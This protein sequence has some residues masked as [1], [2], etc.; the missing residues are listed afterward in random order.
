MAILLPVAAAVI[1]L[2]YYAAYKKNGRREVVPVKD[3]ALNPEQLDHHA[4][5][6]AR[7][8]TVSRKTRSVK[9]LVSRLDDNFRVIMSVYKAINEDA[10]KRQVIS[11]ASEWLLD[12]FYKI[13]EQVK[14][15]KQN[16]TKDK[17]VELYVLNNGILKGYPR[18][19][20]IALELISHTDGRLDQ[21]LLI[22]FVK[23]YQSQAKLS[24]AE[25]WSLSLMVR[26]ALIENIRVICEKIQRT[27]AE[28]KRAQRLMGKKP[29]EL[30]MQLKEDLENMEEVNPSYIEHLLRN[31]RKEGIESAEITEFINEKLA[32][33]DTTLQK[34]IDQEHQEQASRKISI[35]NAIT[36]LNIVSALDWNDIFESLS[37]VDEILREDPAGVYTEMDFES[38]NYYRHQIEKIASKCRTSQINVARKAV[39]CA[40]RAYDRQETC[41]EKFGHVGYYIVGKG[42]KELLGQLGCER[43]RGRFHNHSILV[44][45]API[46]V[47]T[48]LIT[49]AFAVYSYQTAF[50][51][52]LLMGFG[53]AV[54]ALIP[55]SDISVRLVNWIY[56]RILPPAFLPKLEYREGIP[57]DASTLVV[58]PTLLPN[59]GVVGELLA[60]LEVYYLANREENLYFAIAGDFKDAESKE[61]PEDK[62]IIDAAL[63]GIRELNRKYAGDKEIFYFFHRHRQY[64]EKQGKWMGWERKRGALVELNQLLLGSRDTSYSVISGDISHL[65][66]VKYVITLDADTN[67]PLDTAKKL[68]GTISHPLNR[69][70]LDEKKGIVVEGYGIIQPRISVDI[71]SASRSVFTRIF[72]GQGGIDPYT[73]ATS[74]VYQDL[75]GEGIFTGKGIYDLN[76]FNRVL[77]DAIPDNAVLSHD[78]LEGSYI[79]TALATDIE[80]IDSYPARYS[81]YI[82]RQHRWVRGDWQL[83]RWLSSIIRNRKGERVRNPLSALTK[84]KIIDNMR[85]STVPVATLLLILLGLTV[86]PGNALAWIGLAV[87]AA[88]FPVVT[89]VLDS[90]I[91]KYYW[92]VRYKLNGNIIVGVK[93]LFYQVLLLFIFLPHRGYVMADAIIRTLYRVYISR[94][95]LLEWVTAAEAER[96]L[97]NDLNSYIKRMRPATVI[98]VLAI[99]MVVFV[100]PYNFGY[101]LAFG[102]LW[103]L[104]PF[105]AYRVSRDDGESMEVL[106]GEAC[107]EL[108]RLSRKT[109]AFYE[110]F[111]G[112]EN[113]YLVPDNYQ[114]NP[115]NGVAHRT[116]PTNIGFLLLSILSARD[117]GYISTVQ[118]VDRIE[119]TI[120][121]IERLET[122]KGHLYNWYDTR[123]LEVLRPFFVS[124]VDS[125]NLVG[126]LITLKQGLEEY[127]HKP[128]IDTKLV[129][130][131][132]DTLDLVENSDRFDVRPLDRLLQRGT[133]S[134]KEWKELLE[135]LSRFECGKSVWGR[136]FS[137]AV[138]TFRKELDTL[139]PGEDEVDSLHQVFSR[140]LGEL[141][142]VELKEA[143][144]GILGQIQD[145]GLKGRIE[146]VKDSV[147]ML[148]DDINSLIGRIIKLVDATDF[149]SLYD[150][151]RN[152]FSI[153]YNVE[154]GVLMNSYY[155]LLASEARL[156]SYLAIVR[157]EVPKK[158]WFKL[159][160]AL[161]EADGYRGLVS[162]AGTMFEYLMPG[163]VMKGYPNTLLYET[164]ATI[165][166]AQKSYGEKRNV[167]WGTSESGYYAFDML[168]NYQYKAFGIPDFGL[169]RGLIND[170]VVS[171]YST[172]LALPYNPRE[173][174]EN[175][176]RLK[177]EG[178]E[179]EYGFYEA[180]DYTPERLPAGKKKG[181]V[182]S[183]MAHHQGMSFISLNNYFNRNIMQ[184]RFH[185]EP[186]IKVGEILLQEKIPFR[187]IITK[188]YKER[189][190][191]L[192]QVGKEEV[193]VV[194]VLGAPGTGLPH[195]HVLSN[196]RYSVVVTNGG[197]G[198]SKKEDIQVTRWREDAIRDRYGTFIFIRDLC[199]NE[200]WSATYQPVNSPPDGYRAVFCQHKAEF[201]RTDENIETHTEVIVAPEDD[202]EIR[203]VTIS[204][205]GN[206]PV[207]ME[208]TSY[209]ETVLT[210]HSADIAHPAFSNLFVRT[211]ALPHYGSL[212]AYRRPREQGK[213]PVWAVHTIT[214]EGETVGNLQYET[215]RCNFIGRGR[216]ISNPAALTQPLTNTTG[217][218]LDPIMSLRR[219]VRVEPGSS[220]RVAYITGIAGSKDEA[221]ELAKKYSNSSSILR[222]FE[223]ALTRS[224]VETS[225][226][227]LKAEQIKTYQ[228]MI[229]HIIFPSPLKRKYGD[230]IRRNVKGQPGLWAYGISGDVPIVLVVVNSTDHVELVRECLKA[231]EYWRL[232][233][234]KVDLVVL[235]EE[236]GGYMQPVQ[237]LLND[238]VLASHGRHM[239]D[240][241]GGVFIRNAGTMPEEDKI[242]LYTAARIVLKGEEGPIRKQLS[243]DEDR[244]GLPRV[245]IFNRYDIKYISRDCPV[246]LHYFNGYGGF[247]KDGMEYVIKLKE[248]S[249]TPAPWINVV[250]NGNF[251]FHVSESGSGFTWAENSRENKLTPWSN[252]PVSDP[253]GEVLYLRDEENGDTWTVTP[254]PI[255]EK[256]GYIIRHGPG[257][258]VF[259]HD[260]HGIEQELV[261]FVPREEP[262]KINL[263][264]LRN[265]SN[266]K[267][268]LGITYFVKPVMGVSDEVTQQYIYT[269]LDES[270]GILLIRNPYNSDFPGRIAF[271]DTSESTRYYTGDRE[272]FIGPGRDLCCPRALEREH[273]SNRTG[274]GYDPCAA[275]QTVIELNPG[276]EREIAFLLGQGKDREE[277]YKIA[278]LYRDTAACR[279][280]LEE[281]RDYWN[282]VLGTVQV[283]TPDLSMDLM[284]NRWLLYQTIACRLWARSA[285]YQSGGAYGYRDQLQDALNA[286][287]VI[288]EATRGQILLHCAHQFVE[289]DVQHWWH[290]G[291]GNRG[292]RTR[293]SDDLLWLPY[294]TAEY[295]YRTGDYSILEEEVGYLEEEP[296]KEGEDER[297]GVP[298][299]SGEKSSV[300]QHCI[301]AIERSLRFGEHG[302]PLMGSGDW[303]DG[304]NTVGNKGKGES[305]WLGWFL[306]DILRKFAHLCGK[307]GE[308]ERGERYIQVA[309]NI[310]R[311]IEE[312]G[313]DGSWY[314][315]AYF[316]DGTPL[317]S[318]ENTECMIDSIAQSWAIISGAG[319]RQRARQA[320]QA[321]EHYLIR[322]DEGIILLLTPPF[323]KG[324]LNPG[325]IKG[326]VP[327]VREN[328]GQY[329][330]AAC[331]VINA[332][333]M[334]GE[335]NK[336]WELYH[337]INPVNHTRTPIE[338]ATYKVEPYVVAADVY[339]VSPHTGRGGWTWYT[340]AAGWMYSVGIEYILGLRINGQRLTVR[341]CI[342]KDWKEYSITYRYGNT[343]YHIIVKNPEGV[344]TRVKE[345]KIDGSIAKDYIL[346]VDDGKDHQ[347]EVL[348]GK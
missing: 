107:R 92:T 101:A 122:W 335:G 179:G 157:R 41:R 202:A 193:K 242:L 309:E 97:K 230:I 95:N 203:R 55:A 135:Y 168:L 130:G 314:R 290:P 297:Y 120:S 247:S 345:L 254:L 56:T 61:M 37:A 162:W 204:N 270:K 253:S 154:E 234:I 188:E 31:L 104:S 48:A 264:K 268:K 88:F 91:S 8:H 215:N 260:S 342:P 336:A 344:N 77:R 257:Y 144:E 307:M 220:V 99:L 280:A 346:L 4:R 141:S 288:P 324:E 186:V 320:M 129:Q 235:N 87:A 158:H 238:V 262:V 63:R 66:K 281:V 78:L 93:A 13:E 174:M 128:V 237:D 259:Q 194:R 232:K 74:D 169:K 149:T 40:K 70:V 332:F 304:M 38:R 102:L 14:E 12:N 218:V 245:K 118:M 164:Y 170:M 322:R 28:W 326:Y 244:D 319:D 117:F 46:F 267:R 199:S 51:H 205:H 302:I 329:T 303:N 181:I 123:T 200:I 65:G 73:T 250:S 341:P 276:E 134:L 89:G 340:G 33:F 45:L 150:P 321:V 147:E 299:I 208:V 35:G 42:R 109:W 16:L 284:L 71:E 75:F 325:Y 272:E 330:H 294:V 216:N 172:L 143:Y 175:I 219:R 106:D 138:E 285:F 115:P 11:P 229:P 278:D 197:G 62:E 114:V 94:A 222:A 52:K 39:E 328:G 1:A 275:I 209:L 156:A 295:V 67:L 339:A 298:R 182:Q 80:L 113:N 289:G 151:A 316:D 36:S 30:L 177:A 347:V 27:H 283:K 50:S 192:E 142:L 266:L 29:S 292:I 148:I 105:I 167:P 59:K 43:A 100:K 201:F 248:Y 44:Y 190:E 26:I 287:Y 108:R 224:Q 84:W 306:C 9:P 282:R 49:S 23:A 187:V 124:T 337:L 310:A 132:K 338:C 333:A 226:M 21:D 171:P 212:L 140:D 163:L 125:G 263:L 19:Y 348:L 83:I 17:F 308:P 185:R 331:W 103:V 274:A 10:R 269:E 146:R 116:S 152:L 223:L 76:I 191:P 98:A 47:I 240:T 236:E 239:R 293:F 261:M 343:K 69:A 233:G 225:Y 110:D 119:K 189:V 34:I 183:Y 90:I 85:R 206:D 184:S 131:L 176:R 277:V 300:Y 271:V 210:S 291:T 60:K 121:T 258:S 161:S 312:N 64:C 79:R 58:I 3:V 318:A 86:L 112:P 72:A 246:D 7:E 68:V 136:K 139:F 82:M 25:L 296:L 53:A 323:D 57:E 241:P 228:D 249:N 214:V 317:G 159:G 217:I 313:W 5:Q 311:A 6:I 207:I 195:C 251:G 96:Q 213:A 173:A 301:R 256:E 178:L 2:L 279:K 20:A 327:G 265:N 334:L 196:G 32:E 133:I 54:I 153:G 198:Y 273:L 137:G 126:Y 81:S 155:D 166:R 252:D 145:E 305:I 165:I 127:I 227:N 286:V 231:H 243:M 211:E 160:R 315:R 221:V 255:R 22:D 180:V 18:V 24:I 15:I 111:A